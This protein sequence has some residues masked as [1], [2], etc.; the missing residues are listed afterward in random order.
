[1]A[2]AQL[3]RRSG[4]A[5]L[6]AEAAGSPGVREGARGQETEESNRR[7]GDLLGIWSRHLQKYKLV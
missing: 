1:M 4:K 3:A 2:W 7:M 6:R 5:T